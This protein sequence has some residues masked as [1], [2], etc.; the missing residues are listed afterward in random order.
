MK[1]LSKKLSR[2]IL[3]QII[4]MALIVGGL[5]GWILDIAKLIGNTDFK[6]PYKAEVIYGIGAATGAGA[7]I[8]WINIKDN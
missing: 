4:V 5:V 3:I 1:Q 7:V 8:G 2:V 6:A